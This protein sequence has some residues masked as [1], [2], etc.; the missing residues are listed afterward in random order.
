MTEVEKEYVT[1]IHEMTE[2]ELEEERQALI[3]FLLSLKP[4]M[5]PVHQH[6]TV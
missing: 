2:K 6:L 1:I 4:D 5:Q 3:S